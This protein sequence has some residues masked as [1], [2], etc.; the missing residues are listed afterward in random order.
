[1]PAE[2]GGRGGEVVERRFGAREVQLHQAAGRVVDVHQ[3]RAARATVLEPLVVAAI[4]LHQLAEA[5][6]PRPRRL[7]AHP[8]CH[9]SLPEDP[10]R[11]SI[12]AMFRARAIRRAPPSASRA[13]ASGRSPRIAR[14]RCPARS[15]GWRPASPGCCACLGDPRPDR[16]LHGPRTARADAGPAAR[17]T[18]APY[19]A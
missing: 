12:R 11:S 4:D 19:A 18:R 17:S 5:F 10:P 6:A 15:R 13:P 2:V 7:C 14:G 8:P 1:M 16:R 9:P 3:Q